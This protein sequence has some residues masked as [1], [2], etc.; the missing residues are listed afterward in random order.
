VK[1]QSS[2]KVAKNIFHIVTIRHITNLV[3]RDT[4]INRPEPV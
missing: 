4:P 2:L 1:W 3:N